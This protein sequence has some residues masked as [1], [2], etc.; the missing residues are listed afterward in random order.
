MQ[1]KGSVKNELK[2]ANQKINVPRLIFVTVLTAKTR[3]LSRPL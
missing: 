3:N 1:D 2:S